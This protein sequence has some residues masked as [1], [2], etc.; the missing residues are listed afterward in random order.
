MENVYWLVTLLLELITQHEGYTRRGA[1][2]HV[3]TYCVCKFRISALEILL[4]VLL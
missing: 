1:F 3:I 4:V 2:F